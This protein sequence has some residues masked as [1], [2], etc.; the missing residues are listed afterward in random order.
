MTLG[1]DMKLGCRVQGGS[2]RGSFP[3]AS[4][5][6]CFRKT[7]KIPMVREGVG[8]IKH[9][10]RNEVSRVRLATISHPLLCS[11]DGLGA[12]SIIIVE[13]LFNGVAS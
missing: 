2:L 4:K 6:G 7:L 11:H 5:L 10:P 8:S 3:Y 12:V 1:Q 13:C 9:P